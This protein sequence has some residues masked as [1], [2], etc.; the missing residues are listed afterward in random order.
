MSLIHSA[1]L[2]EHYPYAYI[3]DALTK[4]PTHPASHVEKLLAHRW[5]QN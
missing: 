1:K 4:L 5:R 3:R 2:N